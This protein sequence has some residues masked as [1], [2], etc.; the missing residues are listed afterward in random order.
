MPSPR[1]LSSFG[2]L[3]TRSGKFYAAMENLQ[4]TVGGVRRG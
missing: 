2:S 1:L 4:S 3:R